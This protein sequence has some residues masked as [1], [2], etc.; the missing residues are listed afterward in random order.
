MDSE[1]IEDALWELERAK[2]ALKAAHAPKHILDFV[3][4]AIEAVQ[5]E[6]E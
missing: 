4:D 5:M 3:A 2:D 6:R 1:D